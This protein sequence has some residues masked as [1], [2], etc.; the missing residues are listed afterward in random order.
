MEA[1]NGG[2]CLDV[3]CPIDIEYPP[4]GQTCTQTSQSHSSDIIKHLP[5][6]CH[7]VGGTI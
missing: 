7:L 3:P 6:D 5:D 1:L 4:S 2:A